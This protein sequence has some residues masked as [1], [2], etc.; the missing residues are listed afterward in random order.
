MYP[1]DE[2]IRLANYKA[3][4]RRDIARRR[5]ACALAAG[6]V[7]R[8]LAWLDRALALWRQFSPLTQFAAV[9]LGLF[10]QRNFFPRLKLLG[11]LAR[12]GPLAFNTAR[13]LGSLFRSRR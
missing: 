1:R 9:P 11:A 12:W 2:L 7:A 5:A 4:L 10:V 3:T 13:S 8:P 6:R